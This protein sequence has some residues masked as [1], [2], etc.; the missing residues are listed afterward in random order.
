MI[1]VLQPYKRGLII[2]THNYMS[3]LCWN[4]FLLFYS[5][6][7]LDNVGL[8]VLAWLHKDATFDTHIQFP[9]FFQIN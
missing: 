4:I 7:V 8:Q 3:L 2:K 1:F 6:N 9:N 5:W